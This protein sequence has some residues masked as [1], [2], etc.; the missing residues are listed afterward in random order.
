MIRLAILSVLIAGAVLAQKPSW[1]LA[2]ADEFAGKELDLAKWAPH[3][4][5]GRERPREVQAYVP[6]AIEVRDGMAHITAR[7]EPAT[8]D[9]RDREF[10][11]GMMTTYGSFAQMYGRFEI[12]CRMPAG[13]GLE[14]R[15]WLLPLTGEIPE[16]DVFDA[17]GSE[18]KKALFGNRWG[19]EKTERSY[20]GSYPVGDL[21]ADF[22]V[23]A[24]EWDKDK[25]IWFVDGVERFRSVDG[26]PHQP[27]YL[28]ISLIVGGI[29]AKYPDEATKFP[30]A[31]DIDYVR[32]FSH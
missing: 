7:R 26:V 23:V 22:H 32:V 17:V 21:S 29:Q 11:S 6:G 9:G 16:I 12:R 27:M 31:F 5:W 25:I 30:A 10:T 24:I 1:T 3:D 19:D 13:R 2:F 20:T 14:A 18:P 15:F 8:Y 28:A 4:P